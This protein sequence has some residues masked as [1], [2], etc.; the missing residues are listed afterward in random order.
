MTDL[1]ITRMAHGGEGIAELDGRVVFVRG[2]YPGD[3]VRVRLTQDKKRFARAEV[4]EVLTRG[5][6]ASSRP[7][8]RPP[9]GPAAATSATSTPRP[10]PASRPTSC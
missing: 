2:A 6:C 4:T 3:V 9:P 7:A 10:R 1:E 5:R 8:R